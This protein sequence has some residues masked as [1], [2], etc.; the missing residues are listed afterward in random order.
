L[1]KNVILFLLDVLT[2]IQF[3]YARQLYRRYC[4]ARISYGN[5]VCPWAVCPSVRLSRCHDPVPNQAQVK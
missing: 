4:R 1:N 5:S 3:F 2:R